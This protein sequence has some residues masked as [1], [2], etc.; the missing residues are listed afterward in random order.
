M[1]IYLFITTIIYLMQNGKNN[2]QAS[3]LAFTIL[4]VMKRSEAHLLYDFI[5]F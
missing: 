4:L 1:V 5:E 3:L 2:M